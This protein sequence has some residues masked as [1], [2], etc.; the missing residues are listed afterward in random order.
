MISSFNRNEVLLLNWQYFFRY[1]KYGDNTGHFAW[2]LHSNGRDTHINKLSVISVVEFYA[3]CC[4]ALG[5]SQMCYLLKI[6]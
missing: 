1:Q 4:C 6:T 5:K 3:K 2:S